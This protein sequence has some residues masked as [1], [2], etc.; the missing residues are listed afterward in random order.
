MEVSYK[1]EMDKNTMIIKV[2][3]KN[4]SD[5]ETEMFY[6]NSI[7]TFLSFYVLVED[8]QISFIYDT[9]E[10]E[11]ISDHIKRSGMSQREFGL[12]II[13]IRRALRGVET[14]ML[15]EKSVV[16]DPNYV[17]V[18]KSCRKFKF[19]Y[20]PGAGNNDNGN[21]KDMIKSTVYAVSDNNAKPIYTGSLF[22]ISDKTFRIIAIDGY[23]MAIRKESVDTDSSNS[24]VVPGKT[25][26]EILK[27]L[28][29]DDEPTI[30]SE[31]RAKKRS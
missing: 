31:V 12:F 24:F 20:L 25:Q 5:Y 1:K 21:F 8:G 29:E 4:W 27:L 7:R 15:N 28:T 26:L 19:C 14:Y 18:D 6:Y 23:R 30:I 2:C 10:M 17:F 3:G 22:D 13:S 11:S 9:T 16:F